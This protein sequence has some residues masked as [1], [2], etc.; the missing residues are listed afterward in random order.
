MIV[1]IIA[2]KTMACIVVDFIQNRSSLENKA[3]TV[4]AR[5]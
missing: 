5:R 2:A 4:Y 3:Y 1:N